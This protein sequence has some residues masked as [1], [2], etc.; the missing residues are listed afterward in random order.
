MTKDYTIETHHHRLAGWAASTA[1]RASKLCRFEVVQGVSILEKAG[2][3]PAFASPD[4]LPSPADL[5]RTHAQWRRDVI[6]AAAPLGIRMSHGVAAKLI[7]TYLKTRLVCGGHHNHER[8]SA[9]HPPID[10][11]LLGAL[12]TQDFGGHRAEWRRLQTLGW[13]NF[14]SADYETTIR[15]VRESLHGAPLWRIEEH[16]QGHQ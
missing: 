5:D 2:F 4:D 8:V 16:W 12:A 14:S 9:L 11:L 3:T 13:S 7:N 1:A 6:A 10:R 15:L